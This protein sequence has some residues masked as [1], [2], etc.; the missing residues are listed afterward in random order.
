MGLKYTVGQSVKQVMPAP[1]VGA[2]A[3]AIVV[4][5]DLHY[6]VDWVSA[7]GHAQSKFF[8]EDQIE[9]AE[10]EEAEINVASAD[11]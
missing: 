11:K 6:R 3:E 1:V 9:E 4:D 7:D 10:V 8:A 2:I 5:G